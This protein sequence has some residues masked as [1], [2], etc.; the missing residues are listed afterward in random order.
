MVG[1]P[2]MFDALFTTAPV[3]DHQGM[4]GADAARARRLNGLLRAG[5]ILKGEGKIYVSLAH[6]ARDVADTLGAY[7]AA[8]ARLDA[9]V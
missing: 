2:P 6:D 4:A 9:A 1:E 5:G 3:T 8:A 7:R